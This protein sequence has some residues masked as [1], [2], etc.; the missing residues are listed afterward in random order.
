[1][2][3]L[4]GIWCRYPFCYVRIGLDRIQIL[5]HQMDWTGLGSMAAGFGLD[6]IVSTQSIPY[7]DGQALLEGIYR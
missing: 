2:S 7:S 1:M 4:Q 3:I 5:G 6:W